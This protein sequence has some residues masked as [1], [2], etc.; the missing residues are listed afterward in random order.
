MA[1]NNAIQFLRG[2][3]HTSTQVLNDG[4][5]Y[6]DKSSNDLYI[7]QGKALNNTDVL[8]KPRFDAINRRLD[9]LGFKRGTISLDD[10]FNEWEII[11][12]SLTK[13][14]KYCILNAQIKSKKNGNSLTL[15]SVSI[16]IPDEFRP[17]SDK[18]DIFAETGELLDLSGGLISLA[19]ISIIYPR[20]RGDIPLSSSNGYTFTHPI[21]FEIL[22]LGW[23]IA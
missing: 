1:G 3:G 16:Q 18:V 23:E 13:Q 21:Y 14:G 6:F 20:V 4:Q 11:D 7:G 12:S 22:N 2:N 8:F 17:K 5:P 19:N 10:P 9:E 15:D